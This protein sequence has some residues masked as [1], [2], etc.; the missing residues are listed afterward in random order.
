M[1]DIQEAKPVELVQDNVAVTDE[2]NECSYNDGWELEE[3]DEQSE[4]DESPKKSPSEL[5]IQHLQ[6]LWSIAELAKATEISIQACRRI[7]T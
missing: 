1:I 4:S 5:R 6:K 7:L 3:D 2:S